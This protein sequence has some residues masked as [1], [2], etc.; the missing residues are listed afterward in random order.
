MFPSIV[1]VGCFSQTA[2]CYSRLLALPSPQNSSRTSQ[3]ANQ[4]TRASVIPHPS[5]ST[6]PQILPLPAPHHRLTTTT[7]VSPD[8]PLPPPRHALAPPCSLCAPSPCTRWQRPHLPEPDKGTTLRVALV[9]QRGLRRR[10]QRHMSIARQQ[11]DRRTRAEHSC[12][13]PRCRERVGKGRLLGLCV[14]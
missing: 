6:T 11:S 14:L 13:R 5:M 1:V 12:R 2:W 4:P 9:L 7:T 10:I 8:S 3:P